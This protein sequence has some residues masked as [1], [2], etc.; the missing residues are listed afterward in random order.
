MPHN[1]INY[2]IM[3][4]KIIAFLEGP[5]DAKKRSEKN[6]DVYTAKDGRT[7]AVVIVEGFYDEESETIFESE[8]CAVWGD[9]EF[10]T[11]VIALGRNLHV[12]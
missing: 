9:Q 4:R 11:K 8:A 12:S 3:K 7:Y 10:L 6:F 5:Q 2:N 1:D